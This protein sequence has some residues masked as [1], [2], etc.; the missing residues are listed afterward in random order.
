MDHSDGGFAQTAWGGDAEYSRDYYLVRVETIFSRWTLPSVAAPFIRGPLSALA[1]SVEGR[2]KITAGL[3]AAA[4]LDHLGFSEVSGSARRAPWD[5]PVTRLEV[6]GGYAIQRNLL[7]KLSY[8]HN[9]RDTARVP[10][11]NLTAAQLVFWF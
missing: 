4:R 2:Y 11:R 10:E 5:A 1:T 8:Q 3:Y 7:L 6:G 9:T